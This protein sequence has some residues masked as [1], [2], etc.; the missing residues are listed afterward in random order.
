MY[1]E[2]GYKRVRGSLTEGRYLTFEANGYAVTNAGKT[3]L[4][5]ATRA[6]SDHDNIHQRWI[7]HEAD[8][9]ATTFYVSSAVDGKYLTV[10]GLLTADASAAHT[11]T[12]TNLG[13]SKGYTVKT[14]AG[15]YLTLSRLGVVLVSLIPTTFD[16]YSV[17]YAS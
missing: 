17:T 8:V 15:L 11:F 9:D 16:I 6:T 13:G 10:L 4:P 12:I 2:E 7:L 3:V 5:S 1:T 14:E